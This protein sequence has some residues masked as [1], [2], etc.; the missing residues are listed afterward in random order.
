MKGL[1]RQTDRKE[2]HETWNQS[3]VRVR[4]WSVPLDWPD[5][6]A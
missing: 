1:G 3:L 6:G 2:K 5:G 4:N